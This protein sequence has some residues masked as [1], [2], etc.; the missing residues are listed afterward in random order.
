MLMFSSGGNMV[1][2]RQAGLFLSAVAYT[3]ASFLAISTPVVAANVS[4]S[5]LI[6]GARKAGETPKVVIDT[7]KGIATVTGV[8][9]TCREPMEVWQGRRITGYP[10]T[11]V[12]SKPSRT[13]PRVQSNAP[14]LPMP[15]KPRVSRPS[16]K[17]FGSNRKDQTQ[18]S[19]G[20]PLN[21]RCDIELSDVWNEGLYEIGNT[22]Y[23]L[24]RI[25]AIDNNHDGITDNVGFVFQRTGRPELKAYH[26]PLPGH[27]RISAV[28]N[29]KTLKFSE[30]ALICFGQVKFNVP[31][32]KVSAPKQSKQA[33]AF[34]V[35]DIAQEMK[36]RAAGKP[37]ADEIAA[38]KEAEEKEGIALWIWLSIAGS[39]V[40]VLGGGVF[41]LARK[42]KIRFLRGMK[43]RSQKDFDPSSA[44]E[45]DEDDKED[46]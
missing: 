12:S 30:I 39:L 36:D 29:F 14:D 41:F 8:S 13:A 3:C 2:L 10:T 17:S 7:W 21:T 32:G 42:G 31:E 38:A 16:D 11:R 1:N 46:G 5:K 33:Q 28:K 44:N 23:Y 24:G 9:D 45:D 4:C 18:M 35:P 25:F 40:V 34:A 6:S 26:N 43:K 37:T 19:V 20:G 15:I 22:S 27:L